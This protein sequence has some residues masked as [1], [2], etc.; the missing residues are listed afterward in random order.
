MT[1]FLLS[2]S[3]CQE[4]PSPF[5]GFSHLKLESES[6]FSFELIISDTLHYPRSE[7]TVFITLIYNMLSKIKQ[8]LHKQA[9]QEHEKVTH[10]TAPLCR[11][12]STSNQ[13]SSWGE[14]DHIP[15]SQLIWRTKPRFILWITQLWG[16]QSERKRRKQM[17]SPQLTDKGRSRHIWVSWKL[18]IFNMT[19]SSSLANTH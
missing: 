19:S 13:S 3:N 6:C 2:L 11:Q 17:L 7:H 5:S 9:T 15:V 4:P 14:P 16:T 12:K 10:L 18:N 8:W 1:A